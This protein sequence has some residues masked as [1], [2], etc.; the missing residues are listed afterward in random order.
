MRGRRVIS[1]VLLLSVILAS[2]GVFASGLVTV[3][4][5]LNTILSPTGGAGTLTTASVSVDPA[6]YFKDYT[7]QP[8]NSK[9]WVHVNIASASDLFTWQLNITWNKAILNAS[10][11]LTADNAT[12]IFSL[13]TSAN[14]T[15]SYQ[16]GFVINATNNAKGNA[17]AA[18]TILDN[19]VAP[20]GVSGSGRLV[21]IQFKVVGYGSCDLVISS[22]GNLQTKLLNSAVPP[23]EI[24]FTA[25]NG[26]FSNK[27]AGDIDGIRDGS[28][29]RTV[30]MYDFGLFAQAFGS[31]GPPL[32]PPTPT[33][34]REA[35][36]YLHD[37]YVDMYDF[38]LFAQN[39][40]R[41]VN[42]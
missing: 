7:L 35:D 1:V 11:F 30:D 39:F 29:Y 8:V 37:G 42:I 33:W 5:S 2:S 3:P 19:R 13:T 4:V 21:S 20:T 6:Y 24:A 38:G 22:T 14:K 36:I 31:K 15:S 25:T 9:F 28:G 27:L 26:Y 10:R 12:Y 41:K 23:V 18:E 32:Q 40:G 34:N 17:G 16:L